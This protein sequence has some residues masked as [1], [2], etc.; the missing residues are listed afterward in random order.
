MRF[1]TTAI[2]AMAFACSAATAAEPTITT[3][4]GGGN[5]P[6][7]NGVPATQANLGGVI[8]IAVDKT[9]NVYVASSLCWLLKIDTSGLVRIVAG[10]GQVTTN[11]ADN[12]AATST[13]VC[14]ATFAIDPAGNPVVFSSQRI[15]KIDLATGKIVTIA[16]NG[17]AGYAGDGG[18]KPLQAQFNTVENLVYD[19]S[20]N[21]LIADYGNLRLRR[22]T[23]TGAVSTVAGNGFNGPVEEGVPAL[24][25]RV[26]PK[27]IRLDA[28][29][30]WVIADLDKIRR[31]DRN[32]IIRTIAGG[33]TFWSDPVAHNVLMISPE[34]LAVDARGNILVVANGYVAM[35]SPTGAW[36]VIAGGE[37]GEHFEMPHL[38]GF[39]GD[40]VPASSAVFNDPSAVAFDASGNVLIADKNNGRVRKIVGTIATPVLPSGANA[41]VPQATV[42]VPPVGRTIGMSVADITGDGRKDLITATYVQSSQDPIPNRVRVHPRKADGTF[43]AAYEWPIDFF[44]ADLQAAYLNHDEN[45]DIVVRSGN[46]ITEYLIAPNGKPSITRVLPVPAPMVHLGAVMA[47]DMDHDRDIDLLVRSADDVNWGQTGV[48]VWFNNGNGN[49]SRVTTQSNVPEGTF[50]DVNGDGVPDLLAPDP[51]ACGFN[52][53]IRDVAAETFLPP[54]SVACTA[55]LAFEARLFELR[56]VD[57]DGDGFVEVVGLVRYGAPFLAKFEATGP[58]A[59]AYV[60]KQALY[61]D[62]DGVVPA[63]MDN[64]GHVDLLVTHKGMG[65]SYLH[66]IAVQGGGRAFDAPAKTQPWDNWGTDLSWGRIVVADANNDGCRDIVVGSDTRGM[67]ILDGGLCIR[68]KNGADSP[69]FPL[70]GTA[71]A[72]AAKAAPTAP[73]SVWQAMQSFAKRNWAR[74]FSGYSRVRAWVASLF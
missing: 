48:V 30:E 39:V 66:N 47:V 74:F 7:A 29:G 24:G 45:A 18:N 50:A 57:A 61:A 25:T 51:D 55:D 49:F 68:V 34:G 32:G 23:P 53:W 52:V 33:G 15:R 27:D 40:D 73:T 42:F 58:G 11:Y 17:V 46:A 63:D 22:I 19:A 12:V 3:Y 1:S 6:V 20:G 16:G 21:L 9:G 28:H 59:F 37:A 41:F 5:T 2:A 10:N 71:V 35:L 69:Q 62:A 67:T 8:D 4:A 56:T 36:R 31:I 70:T 44:P 60:G 14:P 26:W 38:A 54:Y 72:P 43:G 13:P 65:V 64:D